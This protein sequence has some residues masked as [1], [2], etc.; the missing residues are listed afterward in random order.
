MV[1]RAD[2]EILAA[3]GKLA[4]G[5]VRQTSELVNLQAVQATLLAERNLEQQRL[6]AQISAK[7]LTLSIARLAEVQLAEIDTIM[8]VEIA[9]R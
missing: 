8:Q 2:L 5:R 1:A 6:F 4:S 7:G 9:E 3:Q